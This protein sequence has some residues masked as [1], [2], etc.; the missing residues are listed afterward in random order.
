MK[1]LILMNVDPTALEQLDD[2][3]QHQKS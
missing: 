1:Y 2:E 3:Q